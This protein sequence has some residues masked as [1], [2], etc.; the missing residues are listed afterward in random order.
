M[1]PVLAQQERH[2]IELR[3]RELQAD[4]ERDHCLRT[5]KSRS[6]RTFPATLPMA[7]GVR[8]WCRTVGGRMA[9]FGQ[10]TATAVADETIGASN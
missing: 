6:R 2:D 10:L 9:S 7:T 5:H 1:N 3:R 4:V 8:A